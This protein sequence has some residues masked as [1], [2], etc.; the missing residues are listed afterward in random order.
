[1]IARTE[2]G[3]AILALDPSGDER[4]GWSILYLHLASN[5]MIKVGAH[6]KAGDP[7]GHPSCEGG[8][9]TGT[10]IHIARKY[11]GEW[12]PASG[13]MAFNLEGWIAAAG[14]QAYLGTLTRGSQIVTACTCSD[15]GSFITAGK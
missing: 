10:H 5:D 6:L 2:T 15:P 3:L 12:M 13:V 7:L 14:S 8:H 4:V 1:M 11:N 9:A